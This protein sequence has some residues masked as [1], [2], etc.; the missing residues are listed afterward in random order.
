MKTTE[1]NQ[2]IQIVNTVL[3]TLW[4]LAELIPTC[5]NVGPVCQNER[6]SLLLCHL[7]HCNSTGMCPSPLLYSLFTN[8]CVCHHSS[9]PLVKF[10]GGT[11]LEGLVTNSD[12]SEYRHEVN[13]L[14][15]WSDNNCLQLNASKTQEMIVDFRKKK[16]PIVPSI[17]NGWTV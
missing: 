17:T 2:E 1:F 6:Y 8:N 4:R 14:V 15:S 10:V 9:V 5:F 3:P 11:T 16:T 7:E 12:E 13:R